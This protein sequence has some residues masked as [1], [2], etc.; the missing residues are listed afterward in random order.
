MRR[1]GLGCGVLVSE[2]KTVFQMALS[3]KEWSRPG[4]RAGYTGLASWVA[5]EPNIPRAPAA[6]MA[7]WRSITLRD[8]PARL[9]AVDAASRCGD[10]ATRRLRGRAVRRPPGRRTT[11]PPG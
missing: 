7:R 6:P 5:G 1:Q 3:Y 11:A 8:R 10:G 4:R 2:R 9:P